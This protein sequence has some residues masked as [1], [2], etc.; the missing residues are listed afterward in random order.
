MLK[1]ITTRAMGTTKTETMKMEAT[2]TEMMETTNLETTTS[3]VDGEAKF[4]AANVS[5]KSFP[6]PESIFAK[7]QKIIIP[8]IRLLILFTHLEGFIQQLAQINSKNRSANS[9]DPSSLWAET[10]QRLSWLQR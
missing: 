5:Q 3:T 8:Y 6:Q 9:G 2:K 10:K 7:K 4:Y 1:A